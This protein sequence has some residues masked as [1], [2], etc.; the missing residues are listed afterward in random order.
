[1]AVR[2][3]CGLRTGG[4][5]SLAEA[6]TKVTLEACDVERVDVLLGVTLVDEGIFSAVTDG[7]GTG[8]RVA[9]A[10]IALPVTLPVFA[11]GVKE[12]IGPL[13]VVLFGNCFVGRPDRVAAPL[14]GPALPI[15][16][17]RRGAPRRAGIRAARCVTTA[18]CFPPR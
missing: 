18:L 17:R 8:P 6:L 7:V 12:V 13:G 5:T 2:G 1:M 16:P 3:A 15:S 4:A 10:L 14:P 11:G 9:L